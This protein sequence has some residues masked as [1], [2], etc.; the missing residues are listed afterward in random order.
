MM[1]AISP[2]KGA[3]WLSFNKNGKEHVFLYDFKC[4]LG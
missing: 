2:I 1:S 4:D 3:E